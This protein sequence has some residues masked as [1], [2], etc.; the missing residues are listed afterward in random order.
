M[1]LTREK[2][3]IINK[4]EYKFQTVLFLPE[5]EGRKGEGG[6]R[7]KGFFKHSYRL[8]DGVWL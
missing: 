6:L 2:P 5:G 1:L 4:P 7:T 3:I 8:L